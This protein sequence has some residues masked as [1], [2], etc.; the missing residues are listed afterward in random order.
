MVDDLNVLVVD[1][2]SGLADLYAVW[3]GD[4]HEVETAYSGQEALEE[5]TADTDIVFLDR[6]MPQMSGDEVL[7]TIRSRDVDCQVVMATGAPPD[8]DILDLP[9]D[10]YLS[11][12]VSED[13]LNAVVERLH[14][15]S[16]YDDVVQDYFSLMSRQ[17]ALQAE[18]QP[19]QLAG[20]DE[21]AALVDEIETRREELDSLTDQLDQEDVD[22]FFAEL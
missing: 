4:D 16:T 15:R 11:K 20:N 12:P 9:F 21:Y 5:V 17:A 3:L 14:R 7:T 18:K 6:R 1:D 2:E 8:F 13:D 19:E 10:A 22:A